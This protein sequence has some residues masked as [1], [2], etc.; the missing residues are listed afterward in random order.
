MNLKRALGFSFGLFCYLFAI[1]MFFFFPGMA[2]WTFSALHPFA[3]LRHSI[4]SRL[5]I[6]VLM[7][8]LVF[9]PGVIGPMLFILR[10]R[11]FK[12]AKLAI[13][14]LSLACL[15]LSAGLGEPLLYGRVALLALLTGHLLAMGI[16]EERSVPYNWMAFLAFVL[17]NFTFPDTPILIA[18]DFLAAAY[19]YGAGSVLILMGR[20]RKPGYRIM[21]G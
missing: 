3:A 2:A 1:S 7:A 21:V 8:L 13:G 14:C 16:A 19:L 15:Y 4:G 6:D 17:A 11:R 20:K 18:A 5:G 9:L 10:T 12:R